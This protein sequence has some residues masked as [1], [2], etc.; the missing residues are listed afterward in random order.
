MAK[1]PR[2][3]PPYGPDFPVT[4]DCSGDKGRTK[5]SFEEETNI[6]S[7]MR[8]FHQTGEL[9]D[10][11]KIASRQAFFGDVSTIGDFQQMKNKV[12]D[13]ELAFG[14]LPSDIRTRFGNKP[15]ELVEFLEDPQNKE[16]AI[17][18]G[19]VNAPE[20]APPAPLA[21]PEAA[22]PV[23]NEEAPKPPSTSG[24]GL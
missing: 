12:I 13:A 1:T 18:L 6:N 7:I 5:Q 17:E 10:P 2:L 22:A 21:A 16:E 9:V 4:L 19:I 23:S 14:D 15:G 8:K 24:G 11:A 20:E 3:A